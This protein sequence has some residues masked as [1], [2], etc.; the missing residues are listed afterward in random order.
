MFL[1]PR[2]EY[3]LF[4]LRSYIL[5]ISDI[6]SK[7]YKPKNSQSHVYMRNPNH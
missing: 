7:N 4:F 2:G 3:F 5:N 6:N 1:A